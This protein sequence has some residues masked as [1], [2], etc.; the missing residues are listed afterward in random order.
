[1]IRLSA[2][3][4][5]WNEAENIGR[6][7]ASLAGVADEVVV[8]DSF[9]TDETAE[10]A[11]QA[12]ARVFQEPFA[13]HI[14]QKNRA[15]DLALHDWALS[16]DA[17]EALSPELRAEIL[18]IKAAP[19]ADGYAFNRLNRYGGRWIRHAGWYPDRKLRLVRRALFRWGGE[20][21]HDRLLPL[22][23]AKLGRLRGDL[24]HYSY[25][26]VQ[27]HLEKALRYA[28]IAAEVRHRAGRR[29]AWWHLWLAPAW[30]FFRRFVLQAGVLDG[31]AGWMIC[32][33]S[34]WETFAKYALLRE[35]GRQGQ[36]SH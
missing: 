5:T 10:L 24:L 30:I 6:C 36:N 27:S 22:G 23:V 28:R 11:R 35:M 33:V 7:L 15:L 32:R 4:I 18:R 3:V 29:A 14:E 21:P 17:D 26:T 8:L 31:Y 1:M 16:L 12:G 34:A 19:D 9:S 20:N 13:G 25:P 2:V